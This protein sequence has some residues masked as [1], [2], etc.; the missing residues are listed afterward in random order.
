MLFNQWRQPVFGVEKYHSAILGHRGENSRSFRESVE[1]ATELQKLAA[2]RGTRVRASVGLVVDWDAWWA[3]SAP[4]AL[5]SQRMSWLEQTRAWHAGLFALGHNVDVLPAE[6]PFED[7]DLVVVPNLYL[8]TDAQAQALEA[9]VAAG[10]RLVVG[11]F[12]GVVDETETVHPGGAPGPLRALL[13]VE[14]DETWPI[15]DGRT[16]TVQLA[17]AEYQNAIW[18]EWIEVT[19]GEFAAVVIAEYSSGELAGKPAVTRRAHGDGFAWYVSSVLEPAG[20]R[21]LLRDVLTAA[22]L[23]TRDNHEPN[24]ETVTRTDGA[25]D[26]TFVLNH[27]KEAITVTVPVGATDLLTGATVTDTLTLAR[28]GAAVLV[29]PSETAAPFFTTPTHRK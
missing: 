12:S 8:T 20:T 19:A 10:G 1:L 26:F 4:E 24:L 18:S 5:P 6:G 23:P 3:S 29:T 11:P 2:V 15:D 7:Y 22:G 28:F 16:E 14:V 25:T 27:G 9:Y 13:G 21:A 17:D